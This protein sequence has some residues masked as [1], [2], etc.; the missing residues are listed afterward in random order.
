MTARW[1]LASNWPAPEAEL[2]LAN[3]LSRLWKELTECSGYIAASWR[4]AR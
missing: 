1:R 4:T 2:A 3:Q